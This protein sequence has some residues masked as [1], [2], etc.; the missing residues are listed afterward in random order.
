MSW[1]PPL[2]AKGFTHLLPPKM[3]PISSVT[4]FYKNRNCP[5]SPLPEHSLSRWGYKA[6]PEKLTVLSLLQCHHLDS[7]C[8]IK[9]RDLAY[10][11]RWFLPTG[12]YSPAE[13]HQIQP[14]HVHRPAP[15]THHLCTSM[16]WLRRTAEATDTLCP[17]CLQGRARPQAI[18][19]RAPS[20]VCSTVHHTHPTLSHHH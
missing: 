8:T 11:L 18:S 5:C 12:Q 9:A 2:G 4:V 14:W 19:Q 7:E 15:R 10:C 17:P 6:I 13:R 1:N 20:Q 16:K 3:A